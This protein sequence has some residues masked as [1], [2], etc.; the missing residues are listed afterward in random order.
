MHM[1]LEGG[2]PSLVWSEVIFWHI[3]QHEQHAKLYLQLFVSLNTSI[4]VE[5]RDDDSR[6]P[7]CDSA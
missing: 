4:F 6:V 1:G 5:K 3:E 7:F 2:F